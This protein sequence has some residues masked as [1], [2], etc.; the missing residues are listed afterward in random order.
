V[1]IACGISHTGRHEKLTV[2]LS[3]SGHAHALQGVNGGVTLIGLLASVLGGLLMGIVFY[4]GGLISPGIRRS[5]VMFTAALHQW[6][7]VPLGRS[8]G[9]KHKW[10]NHLP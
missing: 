7:L 3:Y 4:A 9:A 10:E 5:D 6:M 2:S 1:P 8:F